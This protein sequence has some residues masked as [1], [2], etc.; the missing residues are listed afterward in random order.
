MKSWTT[1]GLVGAVLMM[2]GLGVFAFIPFRRDHL[3]LHQDKAI[4]TFADLLETKEQKEN[5]REEAS[6]LLGKIILVDSVYLAA[7][8]IIVF[9]GG[10]YLIRHK[11]KVWTAKDFNGY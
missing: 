9:I 3:Q 2:L 6:Q 10:L 7:V 1:Q 11:Q 8:G 4:S 5:Y